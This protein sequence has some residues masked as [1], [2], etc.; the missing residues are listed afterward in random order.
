M[1]GHFDG[2]GP[3]MGGPESLLFSG[4]SLLLLLAIPALLFW[5]ASRPFLTRG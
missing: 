4:L 1:P 2:P 3:Y 5:A